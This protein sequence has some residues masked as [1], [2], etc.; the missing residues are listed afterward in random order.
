MNEMLAKVIK[1]HINWRIESDP[2]WCGD[3]TRF[4]KGFK[5]TSWKVTEVVEGAYIENDVAGQLI[6][7]EV[8]TA[9]KAPKYENNRVNWQVNI[10]QDNS[11]GVYF[12]GTSYE[13]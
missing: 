1:N 9:F 10:Y 2:T 5:V 12:N 7:Y 11:T 8:T 4:L 6:K 3:W 13:K